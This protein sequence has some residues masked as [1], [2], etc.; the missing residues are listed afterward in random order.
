MV[1]YTE[2]YIYHQSENI[3]SIREN[4]ASDVVRRSTMYEKL[5]CISRTWRKE[6]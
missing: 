2:I 5:H 1:D 4:Q 3:G 6:K